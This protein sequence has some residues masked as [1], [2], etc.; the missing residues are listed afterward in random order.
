MKIS[1]H[2]YISGFSLKKYKQLKGHTKD[3]TPLCPSHSSSFLVDWLLLFQTL[4]EGKTLPVTL[5]VESNP[6]RPHKQST[7]RW[8]TR[9]GYCS[10]RFPIAEPKISTVLTLVSGRNIWLL[11][12]VRK[13]TMICMEDVQLRF[14]RATSSSLFSS[15]P[16]NIYLSLDVI[17]ANQCHLSQNRVWHYFEAHL[18][19]SSEQICKSAPFNLLSSWMEM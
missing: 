1:I 10:F 15:Q 11:L 3:I 17:L 6:S 13:D 16:A 2:R 8:L 18:N 9:L 14:L 12:W 7:Q 4:K 5:S 19:G